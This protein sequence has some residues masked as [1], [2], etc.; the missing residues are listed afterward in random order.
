MNELTENADANIISM[1]VGNK[2]DITDKREVK[3]ED[4]AKFAEDNN[5]A[6]METSAAQ[7]IN[8]D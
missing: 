4:A 6:F 8:I 5:L 1:L 3:T 7:S 2:C